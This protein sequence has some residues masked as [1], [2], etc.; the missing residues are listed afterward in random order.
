MVNIL[1]HIHTCA[2]PLWQE[3]LCCG[4]EGGVLLVGVAVLGNISLV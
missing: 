4:V 2:N 1:Y 3:L